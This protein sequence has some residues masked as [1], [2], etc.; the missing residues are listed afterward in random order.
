MASAFNGKHRKREK[1]SK[2]TGI[3]KAV[4]RLVFIVLLTVLYGQ[5]TKSGATS[6]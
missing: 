5:V 6:Q 3:L 2:N 1:A 4:V